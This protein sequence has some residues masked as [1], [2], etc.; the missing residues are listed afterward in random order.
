MKEMER[1]LVVTDEQKEFLGQ[2]VVTAAV[3]TAEQGAMLQAISYS[4]L[5]EKIESGTLTQM[6][7]K[8]L[9]TVLDMFK[10]FVETAP[11]SV[12]DAGKSIFNDVYSTVK[13]ILEGYDIAEDYAQK[14]GG[15][16]NQLSIVRVH[17]GVTI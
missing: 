7:C 17:L 6:D 1:V 14:T 11:D 4:I 12:T 2:V 8:V 10:E 5:L 15:G 9:E 13:T 16:T 3:A